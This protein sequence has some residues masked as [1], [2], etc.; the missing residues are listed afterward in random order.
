MAALNPQYDNSKRTGGLNSDVKFNPIED[1]E[2]IEE[3]V[4]DAEDVHRGNFFLAG[5]I[6]DYMRRAPFLVSDYTDALKEP[7]KTFSSATFMFF[8]TVFS[9][10]ALGAHLQQIQG[11]VVGVAEYL[12]AN[13][14]S[15]LLFSLLS[16][17]NE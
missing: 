8:A 5:V 3:D 14:I 7:N 1:I 9:T 2:D 4:E 12:M 6:D 10:I 16:G 11:S 13:A 15:G 17:K